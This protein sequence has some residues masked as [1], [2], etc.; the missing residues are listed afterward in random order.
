MPINWKL[1][2]LGSFEFFGG[3]VSRWHTLWSHEKQFFGFRGPM[4]VNLLPTCW[5]WGKWCLL[6]FRIRIWPQISIFRCPA[7]L[8]F[9]K[10]SRFTWHFC[11]FEVYIRISFSPLRLCNFWSRRIQ[12]KWGF[13]FASP[14]C[15]ELIKWYQH[16]H[17]LKIGRVR[18]VW[19]FGGG[20]SRWHTLWN[21]EKQFFWISWSYVHAFASYLLRLTWM[22][23]SSTLRMNL[24]PKIDFSMSSDSFFSKN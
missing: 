7:A 17:K 10:T 22:M 1:A 21:H 4:C 11:V 16:A 8:F 24:A 15:A 6:P 13:F 5:G 14:S 19:S 20:V 12:A 18:H 23:S 3:G 2:E 9:K